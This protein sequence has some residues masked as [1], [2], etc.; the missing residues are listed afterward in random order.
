MGYIAI[1]LG[2]IVLVALC[3]LNVNVMIASFAAAFAVTVCAGL[4]FT[5]SLV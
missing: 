5:D 3:M 2:F 4:P 1:L